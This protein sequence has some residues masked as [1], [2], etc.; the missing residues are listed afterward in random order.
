MIRVANTKKADAEYS[1]HH[2]HRGFNMFWHIPSIM[3][4]HLQPA[5]LCT[6]Q[7][8]MLHHLQS[9]ILH[10]RKMHEQLNEYNAIWISV[11][12][13]NRLKPKNVVRGSI[14]IERKEDNRN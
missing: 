4:D 5:L 3:S 6:M 13:C 7:I 8:G 12:A 2:I 14:S 10:I 9:W 1:S 11:P